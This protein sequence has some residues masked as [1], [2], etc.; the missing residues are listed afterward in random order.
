MFMNSAG[1]KHVEFELP[2]PEK[3]S[4]PELES[5]LHADDEIGYPQYF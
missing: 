2:K 1:D 4:S 3:S 5:P